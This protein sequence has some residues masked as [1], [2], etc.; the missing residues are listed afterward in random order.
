MLHQPIK[1][2]TARDVAAT[3]I[4]ESLSFPPGSPD[5]ECRR[6]AAWKLD[7]WSQGI[8]GCDWTD[9]PP[10]GWLTKAERA[11]Q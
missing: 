6:I 7:Q 9:A 11:A 5:W 8:P 2:P 3:L 1:Q 4:A 10:N